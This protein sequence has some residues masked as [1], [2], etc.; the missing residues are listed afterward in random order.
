MTDDGF[1]QCGCHHNEKKQEKDTL[2]VFVGGDEITLTAAQRAA[3]LALLK[4]DVDAE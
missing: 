4:E 3:I 1:C 2:Q